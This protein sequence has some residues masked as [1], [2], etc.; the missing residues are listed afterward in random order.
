MIRDGSQNEVRSTVHRARVPPIL[1]EARALARAR[2]VNEDESLKFVNRVFQHALGVEPGAEHPRGLPFLT[3]EVAAMPP[4][5]REREGALWQARDLGSRTGQWRDWTQGAVAPKGAIVFFPATSANAKRGRVALS[6]GSGTL[7]CSR[8]APGEPSDVKDWST[9]EL[10]RAEGTLPAGWF[11]PERREGRRETP[12]AGVHAIK[13]PAL[14][15]APKPPTTG[16]GKSPVLPAAAAKAVTD[17]EIRLTPPG[18]GDTEIFTTESASGQFPAEGGPASGAGAGLPQGR[19]VVVAALGLKA[20]QGRLQRGMTG[21]AVEQLQR[22]L[23]ALG[24]LTQ[25]QMK[26]GLGVFGPQTQAALA[27]FQT[28]QGLTGTGI[29]GPNTRAAMAKALGGGK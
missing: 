7:R 5:P 26:A 10:A 13:V 16:R 17:P 22:A 4:G 3:A 23:V 20:P 21:D 18:G 6:L 11:L 27:R 2:S 24:F 14:G 25:A 9:A 28:S 19:L 8:S 15:A 12:S 1:G 29:Y